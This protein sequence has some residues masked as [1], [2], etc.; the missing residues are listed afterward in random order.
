MKS[1]FII[2][3]FVAVNVGVNA[4]GNLTYSPPKKEY[5]WS[6]KS[7]D[8]TNIYSLYLEAAVWNLSYFKVLPQKLQN[9]V[10]N[11]KFSNYENAYAYIR[12]NLPEILDGTKVQS[13]NSNISRFAVTEDPENVVWKTENQW[14]WEWE[15]KYAKWITEN[16]NPEFYVKYNISTDC[17]DNG[18]AIRW[19]FSRISKLP[20]G[21]RLAGTGGL[22]TNESMKDEWKN[23]PTDPDWFK[24][25][26]FLAALNYVL[27]NVYT[28][29]LGRDAYPVAI[30]QEAFLAGTIGLSLS[31]DSG[32]TIVVHRVKNSY[33][34]TMPVMYLSSTSPRVVRTLV[35]GGFFW[36]AVGSKGEGGVLKPLWPVKTNGQWNLLD[37]KSMPHYSEEQYDPNFPG[38]LKDFTLAFYKRITPDFDPI[39]IVDEAV[40]QIS[41]H[42]TERDRLVKIGYDY[43]QKNNCDE[44]TSGWE[45]YSTPLR[46][47]RISEI[48]VQTEKIV[49]I[50][51]DAIEGVR[52]KWQEA[53]ETVV[54]KTG[55]HEFSIN[56]VIFAWT[57]ETYSS[58]PYQTPDRRW[59]LV[60]Q[61]GAENIKNTFAK[62]LAQRQKKIENNRCQN[63][64]P[65]DENWLASHTSLE[66]LEL[67]NTLL[68]REQYCAHFLKADCEA[69]N[70]ILQ[71][72]S[73]SAGDQT[74]NLFKWT[75]KALWFNSDPRTS[76][77]A[78]WGS[79][80]QKM[81][82][83]N[84]P[85]NTSTRIS[86][87]AILFIFGASI[88]QI[89]NLN[90][91][92]IFDLPEGF[93][94]VSMDPLFGRILAY[95]KTNKKVGLFDPTN[96]TAVFV[97]DTPSSENAI[98]WLSP[99]TVTVQKSATDFSIYQFN[100]TAL[101]PL[102]QFSLS[103]R[104]IV[105]VSAFWTQSR[106]LLDSQ[107]LVTTGSDGKYFLLDTRNSN[108]QPLP[109]DFDFAKNPKVVPGGVYFETEN[110]Y[111]L[112][113]VSSEDQYTPTG[114][115]AI[116][117]LKKETFPIDFAIE[118]HWGGEWHLVQIPGSPYP[119]LALAR[120]NST[121]GIIEKQLLIESYCFECRDQN[122]Y[123][124]A[125]SNQGWVLN[126]FSLETGL[127]QKKL[128]ANVSWATL[129]SDKLL[130]DGDIIK[131]MYQ[132]PGWEV[133]HQ[134]KQLIR[135]DGPYNSNNARF[136][137]YS[138]DEAALYKHEVFGSTALPIVTGIISYLGAK[139]S[140]LCVG[141][142]GAPQI[143][144]VKTFN[145]EGTGNCWGDANFSDGNLLIVNSHKAYYLPAENK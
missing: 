71:N 18:F 81:I 142:E 108:P 85:F 42:I 38:E 52:L 80:A 31:G 79:I 27:D 84:L 61:A 133:L 69:L 20:A 36:G 37:A 106:Q 110:H 41:G 100:G 57:H 98:Y 28:H 141:G 30:T 39:K 140:G 74:L 123:F 95:D 116:S 70:V 115:L 126:H 91:Q 11:K 112:A 117:K 94:A 10:W 29:T 6:T 76:I 43:C 77:E 67:Q 21:N 122:P 8:V 23:L 93:L 45:E 9:L 15:I 145:V 5:V 121:L 90:T 68:E 49:K 89:F 47:K 136:Y 35:E 113:L 59:G 34:G 44:G 73:I 130:V 72:E 33:D 12:K 127:V 107:V 131:T 88:K 96:G 125:L 58:N 129:S 139:N 3:I 65:K 40:S 97:T 24:D 119:R 14:S 111:L 135:A 13:L 87:N 22:F 64:A 101:I 83:V 114:S 82:E 105:Q 132:L 86:K 60:P 63:C 56:H 78:R 25:K 17:A 109:V 32:H 134:N 54:L 51:A 53:K 103:A 50:L 104:A 124:T 143:E 75:E 120:L 26:R 137:S 19:I 2:V 138:E 144:R 7:L 62:F 4:R 48:F 128:S 46:D 99:D 66:D 55:D 92:K 102:G 118:K 16:F 1:L